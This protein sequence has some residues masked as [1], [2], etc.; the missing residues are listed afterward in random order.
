MTGFLAFRLSIMHSA[1][2]IAAGLKNQH[3]HFG[4]RIGKPN[5]FALSASGIT[6]FRLLFLDFLFVEILFLVH[7][8]FVFEFFL[9]Q[10]QPRQVCGLKKP[11]AI[12]L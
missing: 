3:A 7:N 9:P 6:L 1:L 12:V 2:F 11:L 5:Y 8:L 4:G 10:G